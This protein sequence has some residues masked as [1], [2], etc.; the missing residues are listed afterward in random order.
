MFIL[1]YVEIASCPTNTRRWTNAGLMFAHCLRCWPNIN[2]ELIQRLVF[3]GSREYRDY[4]PGQRFPPVTILVVRLF[5]IKAVERWNPFI[6]RKRSSEWEPYVLRDT[7]QVRILTGWRDKTRSVSTEKKVLNVI[8]HLLKHTTTLI[9]LSDHY[10]LSREWRVIIDRL[11][12]NNHGKPMV[13]K[14]IRCDQAVDRE[15]ELL[16]CVMWYLNVSVDITRDF[17]LVKKERNK[18][19]QESHHTF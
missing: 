18:N 10:I 5:H 3:A 15:L 7:R 6:R 12:T 16:K 14:S 17:I 9:S 13:L 8:I 2:P 11:Q 1:G 4:S 19:I